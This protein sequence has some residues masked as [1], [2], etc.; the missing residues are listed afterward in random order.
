MTAIPWGAMEASSPI[1]VGL[2]DDHGSVRKALQALLSEPGDVAVVGAVE[3]VDRALGMISQSHPDVLLLDLGLRDGSS[4]DSIPDLLARG[5]PDLRI[6][7]LTMDDNPGIRRT[8]LE[9][10][11]S[12][13]LLKD[14]SPDELFAAIRDVADGREG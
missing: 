10:G 1:T 9:R 12:A 11:A 8:A 3:S 13:F 7:I 5:G 4:L 2:V 6:V 14:A